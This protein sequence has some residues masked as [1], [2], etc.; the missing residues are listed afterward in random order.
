MGSTMVRYLLEKY[1]E[2]T[3]INYDKMTYAGNPENLVDIEK[4]PRYFFE[5]GDIADEHR[6]EEVIARHAPDVIIN[7]A[8]ETHVDRSMM[9]PKAFMETDVL[10]TH[11]LLEAVKRHKISRLV[12]ISTDEVYGSI[13]QG[14]FFEDS[15]FQ[16]NNPYSASK[17]GGDHMCRAYWES[18]RTPVIVT[19]S[20]NFFGPYQ[21]PEKVV[22]L[23]ITNILEGKPITVHGNGQQVR[24][25]IY[26]TDHCRAVDAI[27]HRGIAGSVYNIGTGKRC[28]IADLA[29][30]IITLMNADE[31]LLRYGHDRPGQ[32]HRYATNANKL[33]TELDWEPL[34]QFEDGMRQTIQWYRDHADWWKRIKEGEFKDYYQQLEKLYSESSS[35]SRS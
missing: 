19:H 26:A 4:N 7:Y 11:A 28:T 23:F 34:T 30:T 2:Y 15:S 29:K 31:S 6:V 8:A 24:E 16:P 33:R 13:D 21:H 10:G 35:A 1:P 18:Y 9:Y 32:D 14:E 20:C 5:K 17:A 12:H 25:W 27:V 22:P 3:V